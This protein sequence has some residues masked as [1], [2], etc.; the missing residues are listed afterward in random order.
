[1]MTVG[2][3]ALKV[4]VSWNYY[5]MHMIQLKVCVGEGGNKQTNKQM[6]QK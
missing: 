5:I 4:F 2:V 6:K 3:N 1:M